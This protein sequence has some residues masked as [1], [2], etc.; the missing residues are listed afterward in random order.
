M[1]DRPTKSTIP[2]PAIFRA[3]PWLSHSVH[4]TLR[5]PSTDVSAHPFTSK[6]APYLKTQARQAHSTASVAVGARQHPK[7]ENLPVTITKRVVG[8]G[9]RKDST[10]TATCSIAATFA[11]RK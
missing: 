2:A 11:H 5:R 3:V 10:L 1:R 4:D 8:V 7:R 6:G 9:I